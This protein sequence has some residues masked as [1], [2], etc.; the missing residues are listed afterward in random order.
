MKK[1]RLGTKWVFNVYPGRMGVVYGTRVDDEPIR[2]APD[3]GG[4][5][6][7]LDYGGLM[8]RMGGPW[9]A[10][11]RDVYDTPQEA[12]KVLA[13]MHQSGAFDRRL[14]RAS[15]EKQWGPTA[16]VHKRAN[17]GYDVLMMVLGL[18]SSEYMRVYSAIEKD[19]EQSAELL[20]E[21]LS[22]L[23]DELEI[24]NGAESALTRIQGV[25]KNHK[26]WGPDL[27]R[28]NIFKAANS[29][30]IHLPSGMFASEVVSAVHKL[31]KDLKVKNGD[32]I[33]MGV[34]VKVKFLG[35]HNREGSQACLVAANW[36][37]QES[38]RDYTLDPVKLRIVSLPKFVTGFKI[39]S[40]NSIQRL[41]DQKGICLT[42]TGK[43][44]EPDGYG[45]DDSPSWMLVLGYV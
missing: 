4:V 31:K 10:L 9:E 18:N 11:T 28:N 38:G 30:G 37:S 42:P 7:R 12:A 1:D 20:Q 40:L 23:S 27:L 3:D 25:I 2:I 35:R 29:L 13:R 36:T 39:P 44:V 43:R 24:S 32:A 8:A 41:E 45:P 14:R 5:G 19:D 26:H 15:L 22:K 21:V 33:P 16:A 17:S 34:R 6:W